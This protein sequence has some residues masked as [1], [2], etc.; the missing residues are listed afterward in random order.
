[1]VLDALN[2]S[3]YD[4]IVFIGKSIGTVVA[5]KIKEIYNLNVQLILF[6]PIED[7]L[8]YIKGKNNIL[9]VSLG[10]KDRILE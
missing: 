8:R 5:C 10:T 6:T 9:L 4:D 2:L 1:M 3:E 7:T